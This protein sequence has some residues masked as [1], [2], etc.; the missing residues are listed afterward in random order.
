MRQARVERKTK[1]SH[2]IVELN[3]DGHRTEIVKICGGSIFDGREDEWVDFISPDDECTTNCSPGC[4]IGH[5]M[6]NGIKL[7]KSK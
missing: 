1:E 7:I 3:L 2:V 6:P 5:I 4:H